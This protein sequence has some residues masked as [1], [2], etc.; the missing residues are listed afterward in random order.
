[1]TTT[2][3]SSSLPRVD[4]PAVYALHENDEWW[5]PFAAAFERAGVPV[6]AWNLA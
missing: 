5:P 3:A 4:S 1:M 6:V 2:N